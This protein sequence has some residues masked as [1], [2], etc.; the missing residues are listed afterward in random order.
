MDFGNHTTQIILAIIGLLAAGTI[1]F[2]IIKSKNSRNVSG[3]DNSNN[4]NIS[5]NKTKGDIAGRDINKNR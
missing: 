5:N 1:T 2:K 3:N 4:V